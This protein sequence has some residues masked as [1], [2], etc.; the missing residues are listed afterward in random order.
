MP[1]VTISLTAGRQVS[2][3][4]PDGGEGP[5]CFLLG[6]R[7][8]GS[9]ILNS[10]ASALARLNGRGFVDVGHT[11]FTGNVL[12]GDWQRDAALQNI[13]RPGVIYGGFRDMPLG[14]LND[15]VFI[16]APKFLM[17]RDPRD[18]LVSEY[19][20]NAYSHLIPE[21]SGEAAA[22]TE[23]MLA[24]RELALS[25]D[26]RDYVLRMARPMNRTM[27][28]FA[29][30]LHLP[31]LNTVH[32]EDMI[33]CKRRLIRILGR[34]FRLKASDDDIAG[35]L[36][37]ADEIPVAENPRAFV[38]RVVP[39]DHLDKLDEPTIARL[40]DVLRPAMSMFGYKP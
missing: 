1:D 10:I 20:S 7:K 3:A 37:W 21:R 17:V 30:L 22:V 12:T 11:F 32:Y 36:A 4:V 31:R 5:T 39:R 8:S 9:S 23:K 2:F 35:I 13:L 19:F 26:I 15:K 34:H 28:L 33:L 14:L 18:A 27:C 24:Q 29:P 6:V 38:R 16:G 40:N 25:A